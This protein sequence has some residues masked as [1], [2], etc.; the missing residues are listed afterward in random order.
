MNPEN[1]FLIGYRCTGKSSVGRLLAATLD[2][3][4]IDTDSLVV[5]KSGMSIRE[6]VDNRGWKAFRGLECSALQRVC[7][8]DR[9]VVATGGGIVLHTDNIKLMKKSGKI[10]WLM[11]SPE[12]I[13]ARMVQDRDS[14]A[15]RP[16]LTLTD[17]ISEIEETLIE[18]V[19]LY[20]QAMD[21]SVDTDHRGVDEICDVIIGCLKVGFC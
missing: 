18:R 5:S 11:A 6:I 19:H 14:V 2:R 17:S 12:T 3:S 20:K 16:A 7:T 8:A 1:L 13:K 21:F 4:F 15:F 10:I 9:Q